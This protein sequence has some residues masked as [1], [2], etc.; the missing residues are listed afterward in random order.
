MAIHFPFGERNPSL[1]LDYY[2][3]RFLGAELDQLL[4]VLLS[5]SIPLSLLI[6]AKHPRSFFGL[7]LLRE[8]RRVDRAVRR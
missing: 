6:T 3:Q 8:S 1:L 2:T 4:E 5:L 7:L